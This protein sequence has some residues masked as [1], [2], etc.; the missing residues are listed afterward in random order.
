MNYIIDTVDIFPCAITEEDKNNTII[1][2]FRYSSTTDEL[3]NI[4]KSIDNNWLK[5]KDDKFLLEKAKK[6]LRNGNEVLEELL[7]II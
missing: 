5:N 4:W 1:I 7:K 6:D 2:A 3:I